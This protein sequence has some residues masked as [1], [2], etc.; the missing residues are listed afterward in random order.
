MGLVYD[1]ILLT[2]RRVARSNGMKVNCSVC[3]SKSADLFPINT[4][5]SQSIDSF[6]SP[7]K[8]SSGNKAVVRPVLAKDYSVPSSKLYPKANTLG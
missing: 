6:E 2:V 7:L 4:K 8:P 1:D 3:D 5:R